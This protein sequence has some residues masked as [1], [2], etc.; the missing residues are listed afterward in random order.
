MFTY[1]DFQN[2]EKVHDYSTYVNCGKYLKDS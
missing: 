1:V 2:F